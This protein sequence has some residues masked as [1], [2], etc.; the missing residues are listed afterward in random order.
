MQGLLVS[1]RTLVGVDVGVDPLVDVAELGL[2]EAAATWDQV[3]LIF[4]GAARVLEVDGLQVVFVGVTPR[5]DPQRVAAV[6]AVGAIFEWTPELAVVGAHFL[7]VAFE[8]A[9][10]VVGPGKPAMAQLTH[11]RPR[12]GLQVG[13]LVGGQVGEVQVALWALALFARL[14]VLV[15]LWRLWTSWSAQR[16]QSRHLQQ[17]QRRRQR[18]RQRRGR[19]GVWPGYAA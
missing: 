4:L 10:Q 7:P 12:G 2:A 13:R 6:V 8:V 15:G 11:V 1:E 9:E 14:P 18:D 5:E 16:Q 3:P 19:N 17:S